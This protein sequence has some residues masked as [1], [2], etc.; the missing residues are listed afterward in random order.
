MAVL[1]VL[2][3]VAGLRLGFAGDT[4]GQAEARAL[5][6]LA[7]IRRLEGRY[8]TAVELYGRV[9]EGR[10]RSALARFGLAA[11]L[12]EKGDFAEAERHYRILLEDGGDSPVVL[13][14]L[15]RTLRE[16]GKTEEAGELFAR[17]IELYGDRL[18]G[19]AASCAAP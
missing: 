13:Y 8:D 6:G 1:A 4:M 10:D 2:A 5:S 17:F 18:P 3:V 9:M 15:G 19:L 16:Q 7:R 11:T 14:N 12:F